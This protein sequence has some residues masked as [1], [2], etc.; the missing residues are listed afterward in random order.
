M[1]KSLK[2]QGELARD[3]LLMVDIK[4]LKKMRKKYGNNISKDLLRKLGTSSSFSS[5]TSDQ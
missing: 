2:K 5:D 3:I 1:E 4:P